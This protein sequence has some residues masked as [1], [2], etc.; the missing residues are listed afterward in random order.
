[1]K[2]PLAE[3]SNVIIARLFGLEEGQKGRRGGEML[4]AIEYGAGLLE[5]VL[6]HVDAVLLTMDGIEYTPI[7]VHIFI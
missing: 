4:P 7:S 6:D 1:M 3:G 5:E 2:V